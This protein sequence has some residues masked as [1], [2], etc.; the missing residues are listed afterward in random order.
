MVLS[1][2]DRKQM[3][4][5]ASTAIAMQAGLG[6]DQQ[7]LLLVSRFN[8]NIQNISNDSFMKCNYLH[9]DW[10]TQVVLKWITIIIHLG[11]KD[12]TLETSSQQVHCCR[13]PA[14]KKNPPTLGMDG[15]PTTLRA[16]NPKPGRHV[17]YMDRILYIWIYGYGYGYS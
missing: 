16:Q 15:K 12:C 7:E 14:Q 17:T 3:E 2:C 10:Q 1:G 11:V 4:L 5:W 8:V 9:C 6:L 13:A